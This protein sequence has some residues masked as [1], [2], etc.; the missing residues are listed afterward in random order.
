MTK[1]PRPLSQAEFDAR[2]SDTARICELIAEAAR[3]V[4]EDDAR[5]GRT[6]PIW[7]DGAVVWI[8]PPLGDVTSKIAPES[9]MR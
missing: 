7:Q 2:I 8:P 5:A 1:T 9:V 6:V 3:R 4:L